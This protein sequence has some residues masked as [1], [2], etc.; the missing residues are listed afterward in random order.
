MKERRLPWSS[1]REHRL[2]RT[3]EQLTRQKID[4]VALPTVADLKARRLEITKASV[5][6]H[7][8]AADFW[9]CGRSSSRWR[10]NSM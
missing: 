3:I 10:A 5:R 8:V 2:L 1:L 4:V 6:E 7:L 9:M